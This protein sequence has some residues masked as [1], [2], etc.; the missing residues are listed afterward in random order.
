MKTQEEQEMN[1][2]EC[3]YQMTQNKKVSGNIEAVNAEG[4]HKLTVFTVSTAQGTTSSS[5]SA[6]APAP[7]VL[8]VQETLLKDGLARIAGKERTPAGEKGE[9]LSTAWKKAQEEARRKHIN[10][11]RY[12]D[13]CDSDDE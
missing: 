2:G 7:M 3:F 11:W 6:A 5:S 13:N 12:G 1:A 8:S 9:V 10:L 4:I